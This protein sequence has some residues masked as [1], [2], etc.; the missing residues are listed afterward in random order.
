MELPT[1][2][3][4]AGCRAATGVQLRGPLP[5]AGEGPQGLQAAAGGEDRGG[6]QGLAEALHKLV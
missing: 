3:C 5:G 2:T 1:S 6:E 4:S